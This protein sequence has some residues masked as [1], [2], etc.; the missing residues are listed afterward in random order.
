MNIIMLTKILFF[1]WDMLCPLPQESFDNNNYRIVLFLAGFF[2]PFYHS[3]GRL[4][5]KMSHSDQ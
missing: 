3:M 5:H 2:L 4:A 1:M